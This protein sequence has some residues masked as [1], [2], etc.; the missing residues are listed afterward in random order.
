MPRRL[1]CDRLRCSTTSWRVGQRARER[2]TESQD[3][4]FDSR[5]CESQ[6][7]VHRSPLPRRHPPAGS[8]AVPV[9][10]GP[11]VYRARQRLAQM[12]PARK[13]C[14]PG[15]RAS[16]AS[17]KSQSGGRRRQARCIV[18]GRGY[19]SPALTSAQQV[20]PVR[21]VR[22]HYGREYFSWPIGRGEVV[23]RGV[24]I[25]LVGDHDG[26]LGEPSS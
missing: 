2:G 26:R 6:D 24:R 20:P 13:R 25:R 9:G 5:R 23:L 10:P 17:W 1:L 21:S 11:R 8:R 12:R 15:Q 3:R 7:H 14:R 22:P 18:F 4:I 19:R 16:R